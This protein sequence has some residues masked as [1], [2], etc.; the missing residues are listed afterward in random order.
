[1]ITIVVL[2]AIAAGAALGVGASALYV[3]RGN[4]V[5]WLVVQ[6]REPVYAALPPSRLIAAKTVRGEDGSR[7]AAGDR[8]AARSGLDAAE[9]RRTIQGWPGTGH[10]QITTSERQERP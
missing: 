4:A 9:S 6:H 2:I 5:G 3:A 8:A 1:M 10:P 7:L